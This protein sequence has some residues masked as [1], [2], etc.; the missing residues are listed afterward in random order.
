MKIATTDTEKQLLW[1]VRDL[2]AQSCDDTRRDV[3]K[4]YDDP[5]PV[6]SQFIAIHAEAIVTLAAYGI[7]TDVTDNGGRVV[8]GKL[9]SNIETAKILKTGIFGDKPQESNAPR[10]DSEESVANME[11]P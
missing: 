9:L 11:H 5:I 10:W 4:K 6:F 2:V 7:V 1:I 8:A 3:E